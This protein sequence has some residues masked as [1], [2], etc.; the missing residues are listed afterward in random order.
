MDWDQAP[1]QAASRVAGLLLTVP[2]L[3]ALDL[4][5]MVAAA[6]YSG[7]AVIPA[8]GYLLS[9][10]ALKLVGLRRVSHIE[11]LAADA[12]AAAFAGLHM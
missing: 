2:D 11:D 8:T 10:L 1:Q 3:V 4:P 12:G 9:L 7:T 5:A 6:G